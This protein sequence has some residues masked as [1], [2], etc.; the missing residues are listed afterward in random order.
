MEKC[1]FSRMQ[2]EIASDKAAIS[3]R[4]KMMLLIFFGINFINVNVI[5][6]LE[7]CKK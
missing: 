5:C 4:D 7:N 1:Q 2:M 3:T 6:I